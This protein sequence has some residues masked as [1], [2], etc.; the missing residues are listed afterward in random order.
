MLFTQA[1]YV[2][3]KLWLTKGGA[4]LRAACGVHIFDVLI[5]VTGSRIL[6]EYM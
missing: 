5:S 4:R 1:S 2:F 6:M 3:V